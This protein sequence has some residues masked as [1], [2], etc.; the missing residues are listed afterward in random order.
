MCEIE[1]G[2][3]GCG[4]FLMFGKLFAVIRSQGED[5]GGDGFQKTLYRP[6][7]QLCAFALH[8][9]QQGQTGFAFSQ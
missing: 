9:G 8:F 5:F 7:D 3:K 4:H 2:L 6:G 1:S